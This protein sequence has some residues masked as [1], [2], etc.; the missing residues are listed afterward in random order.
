MRRMYSEKQLTSV[1]QENIANNELNFNSQNLEITS[2]E[3][4]A[5]SGGVESSDFTIED[6]YTNISLVAGVLYLVANIKL[7]NTSASAIS[8]PY[9]DKL[10][11]ID[12]EIGDKIYD[13]NGKK[14]SESIAQATGITAVVGIKA[15]GIDFTGIA[16]YSFQLINLTTANKFYMRFREIPSI[17]AGSTVYLMGRIALTI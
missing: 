17:A 15:G 4:K 6:I 16:N 2:E 5:Y 8:Y 1:I 3:W 14:V 13:L 12:K 10:V 11:E 7:T 9:F